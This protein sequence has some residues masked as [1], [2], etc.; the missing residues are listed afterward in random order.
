M[1]NTTVLFLVCIRIRP[2][3][4]GADRKLTDR[5]LGIAWSNM[6]S[7]STARLTSGYAFDDATPF[8]TGPIFSALSGTDAREIDFVISAVKALSVNGQRFST[9]RRAAYSLCFLDDGE[10][11]SSLSAT[12]YSLASQPTTSQTAWSSAACNEL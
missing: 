3:S 12:E 11:S 8:S 9:R 2:E 4:L 10:S 7:S 1:L 5:S 6:A